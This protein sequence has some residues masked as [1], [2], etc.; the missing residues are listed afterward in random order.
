MAYHRIIPIEFNHCDPAGIVFY[1]RYFEMTN[2]VV[3]NFFREAA[4]L[5]FAQI[6]AQ[7]NGVPTAR[8]ETDFLA[9]SRLGEELL[10]EL[11]VDRLGKSS[12]TFRLS[13]SLNGAIRVRAR[14]TLVWLM[15]DHRPGPWPDALR[16][17]LARHLEPGPA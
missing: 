15:P 5:P 14:L 7:Q 8:I 4:D 3:E 17:R 9:P 10:W 12:V 2:S 6:M 11:V 16:D 1:P 13:A